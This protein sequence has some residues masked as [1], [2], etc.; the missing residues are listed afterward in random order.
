VADP[1]PVME[2]V[3]RGESTSHCTEPMPKGRGSKIVVED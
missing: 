1:R 3:Y 2:G